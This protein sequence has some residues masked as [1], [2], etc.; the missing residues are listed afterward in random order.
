MGVAQYTT[1]TFTL[2]FTEDAL[3]LTQAQNVYVTFRSGAVLMTKTGADL[4]I[5]E[6]SIGVYLSQ[7]ET[8]KFRIGYVDIQANWT[9]ATG[10]RAASEVTKY[11]ISEQLLKRVIE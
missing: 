5:A 6:K 4:T 8:A 1:P 11:I 9:T 7:E 2:T 3:D 10:G